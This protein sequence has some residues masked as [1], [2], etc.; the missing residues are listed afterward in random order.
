MSVNKCPAFSALGG[1][2]PWEGWTR[3]PYYPARAA[4]TKHHKA[5]RSSTR[6]ALDHTSRGYKSRLKRWAVLVSSEISALHLLPTLGRGW[7][8]AVFMM[9]CLV[10]ALSQFLSPSLPNSAQICTSP[11]ANVLLR[12]HS[13]PG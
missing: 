12:M 1:G 13:T 2:A 8:L 10:V 5:N 6:N 9:L 11:H 4:I 7:L 3:T